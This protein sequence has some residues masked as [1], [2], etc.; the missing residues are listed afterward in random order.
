M[1]GFLLD[2]DVFSALENPVGNKNVHF[3]ARTIPDSDLFLSAI[4]VIEAQKG[5]TR[6]LRKA[7]T[8][9]EIENIQGFQG[10]FDSV[11]MSSSGRILPVDARVAKHW[12]ELLGQRN[13]NIMD[14]GVAATAAVHKL[15]VATR[16]LQHFRGRGVRL[17]DPFKMNPKII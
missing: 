2:S 15:V 11:L 14:A 17:I 8:A 6:A 13:A 9:N 10:D 4:I 1:T 16:N 3:W 7:R 12:G 5:L